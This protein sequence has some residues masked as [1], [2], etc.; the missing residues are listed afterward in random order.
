[1]CRRIPV[2]RC[3]RAGPRPHVIWSSPMKLNHGSRRRVGSSIAAIGLVHTAVGVVGF[4]HVIV[5]LAADGVFNTVNGEPLR[6]AA[7]WFI[8]FGFVAVLL[9]AVVAWAAEN[10]GETPAFLGSSLLALTALGIIIMPISGFWLLIVP[11]LGALR[12]PSKREAPH[13]S[14]RV[15]AG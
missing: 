8:F 1:M 3:A 14:A 12:S 10:F 4:H 15:A 5:D 9:G 7:F 6:E 13:N 11:T 2:H